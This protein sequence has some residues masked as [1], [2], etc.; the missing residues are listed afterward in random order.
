MPL[1][2]GY[3]V[4]MDAIASIA[5][6]Q[7]LIEVVAAAAK[8][9]VWDRAWASQENVT[10]SNQWALQIHRTTTTGTGTTV[11][12]EPTDEG[13]SAFGGT[14]EVDHSVDTTPDGLPLYKSA[15]SMLNEWLWHPTPEERFTAQ[16]ADILVLS[17]TAITATATISAGVAFR[18][19]G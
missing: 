9:I 3:T 4:V 13:D 6:A 14:A 5:A 2:R 18:E 15:G 8:S 12:P 10:T 7:D 17:L 11:V 19:I 1:G 16:G